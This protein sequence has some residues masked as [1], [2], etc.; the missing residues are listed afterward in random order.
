MN[1][2]DTHNTD[3]YEQLPL[4]SSLEAYILEHRP[5]G[6]F[7]RAVISN[8]LAAACG[9][10]DLPNQRLLYLYVRYLYNR[11]PSRCWG[12]PEAYSEWVSG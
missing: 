3:S 9:R 1:P 12:S 2:T 4:L 5:V 10:G 7:L 6:G 11:S 8:D